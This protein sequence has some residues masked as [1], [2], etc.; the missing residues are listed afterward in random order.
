MISAVLFDLDGTLADTA[1]DLGLALNRLLI[2][3]SLPPQPYKAIRPVASH[4][5]RGLIELGFGITY[6]HP[7]FTRLRARFLDLYDTCFCEETRLFEG[8]PEVLSALADRGLAWGIVTNKPSRFTDPLVAVLGFPHHPGAVVSGD[9]V[10]V[11]K[12]DPLPMY[13]AAELLGVA[14]ECC[15]YVG[16]AER[17]IEAGRRAGMK[18]VLAD[19]G[20]I[21]EFDCPHEWGADFRIAHPMEL[22]THLPIQRV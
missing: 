18:T 22:L 10:G 1:P 19:Y 4:G 21:A 3:E 6:E 2:E 12:P 17:D 7:D 9:T 15:L 11:P 13:H 20:Y 14:P 8:V 5:A 16:D